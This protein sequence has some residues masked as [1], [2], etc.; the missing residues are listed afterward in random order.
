[1]SHN[2]S[3]LLP[4]DF[5]D[6]VRDLIGRELEMRFEAFGTGPDGG[7]DG[8]CALG[9]TSTILQAKHYI[10][11]TF[12]K[13]K[14]A[15]V[16]ERKAIN[17]LNPSRYVLATSRP[18]S[19]PNKSALAKIIG[20]SL[21]RENDIFSPSD[22]N[23]L[24]RKYPD[25]E[26]AHIKLWLASAAILEKVIRSAAYNFT[27]ISKEEISSKVQVY[28]QNPSFKKAQDILETYH[29]LIVSGPPGVGKTTL[30]EMLSH[31]Y[32][33]EGWEFVAIRS[34]D[35]G[36]AEIVDAKQQIFFFDDFLGTIAL[37]ARALASKDSDLARFMK[38]IR[39]TPNARFILT[40]RTPI[41]EEARL[42]S[43]QL[44][45]QRLDIS[46]YALDV[47]V[48]TR[49]IK[50][51]ILYNHLLV[52]G[53]SKAHVRALIDSGKIPQ[54]VD[55]KNYNPRVIEWMTDELH[56]QKIA[57]EGYATAFLKA[58]ANPQKLWDTTFRTQIPKK[59]QHLLFSL[60][61]CSEY[62]AEI[63]D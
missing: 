29:V 31:A 56:S 44:A 5:E 16:K 60:F 7:I 45:D 51:R 2:F 52:S 9:A 47:G 40:T 59:C 57:T 49:R 41:F 46:R 13:L 63:E 62:G 15:M 10:G 1:M 19:A 12:S 43:E 18:L 36:F 37:D 55:H 33:G 14:S 54:I 22:L 11:S 20:P 53:L 42:I 23:G 58:L 27:K 25:I 6:L 21:K 3:T 32:L 34:L 35:D 30:A 26:K 8:R 39:A 50:A 61:F 28:A 17:Q 48:Y 4:A 24:L 38:R